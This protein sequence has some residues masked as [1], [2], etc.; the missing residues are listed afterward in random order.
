M[1][2]VDLNQRHV[3]FRIRADYFGLE[4]APVGQSNFHVGGAVH[5]MIVGQY[6]TV[7]TNDYTRAQTAFAMFRGSLKLAAAISAR[8]I[9]PAKG[10]AVAAEQLPEKIGAVVA[11]AFISGGRPDDLSR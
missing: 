8:A 2:G 4:L 9:S 5:D 10:T 6:V 11:L 7:G 3:G 1:I